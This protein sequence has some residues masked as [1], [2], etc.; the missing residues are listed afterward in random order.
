MQYAL[1][2]NW[3]QYKQ[4]KKRGGGNLQAFRG[5]NLQTDGVLELGKKKKLK[6]NEMFEIL[7][8]LW[9]LN[10]QPTQKKYLHLVFAKNLEFSSTQQKIQF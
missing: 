10:E 9:K 2:N 7:H 1:K 5:G 4:A 3:Y 6:T 8:R